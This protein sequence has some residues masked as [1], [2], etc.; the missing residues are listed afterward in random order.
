MRSTSHLFTCFALLALLAAGD[1]LVQS[2]LETTILE[3]KDFSASFK[4]IV[5]ENGFIFEKHS[6]TTKD[7][8]ILQL[9]RIPG[10]KGE[11]NFNSKPPVFF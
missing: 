6:V 7:G 11:K 5:E 4:K 8:Y 2:Q 3:D 1:S 10:K 9:F